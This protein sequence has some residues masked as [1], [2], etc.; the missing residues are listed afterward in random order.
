MQINIIYLIHFPANFLAH[1]PVTIEI[2]MSAE[3]SLT[4]SHITSS[5]QKKLVQ[6]TV[7]KHAQ[8][9]LLKRFCIGLIKLNII[10]K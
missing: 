1:F 9:F 8:F 7:H 10:N 2:N 4:Y 5:V 6:M 3:T